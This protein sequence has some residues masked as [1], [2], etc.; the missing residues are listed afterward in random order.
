MAHSLASFEE[1]RKKNSKKKKRIKLFIDVFVDQMT[2]LLGLLKRIVQHEKVKYS[3]HSIFFFLNKML[4]T[5]EVQQIRLK[6]IKYM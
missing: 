1:T 6:K 2:L 4:T 5:Y 3:L